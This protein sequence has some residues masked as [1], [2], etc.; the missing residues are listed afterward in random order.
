M[1][2]NKSEFYDSKRH[3]F[4][5]SNNI[6]YENC[7]EFYNSKDNSVLKKYLE[8]KKVEGSITQ[9]EIE[10]WEGAIDVDTVQDICRTAI[11]EY[12][13][14]DRENDPLKVKLARAALN[15][16]TVVEQDKVAQEKNN[17]DLF[18]NIYMVGYALKEIIVQKWKDKEQSIEDIVD[19]I[20]YEQ[21]EI[22]ENALYEKMKNAI[23]KIKTVSEKESGKDIQNQTMNYY[24]SVFISKNSQILREYDELQ[25]E[26]YVKEFEVKQYEKS[27]EL[28]NTVKPLK[29]KSVDTEHGENFTNQYDESEQT[30]SDIEIAEYLEQ[31]KESINKGKEVIDKY[32][33][34]K[35]H[36]TTKIGIE[37]AKRIK[38]SDKEL[39]AQKEN[40]IEIKNKTEEKNKEC[41][42]LEQ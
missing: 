8:I 15:S 19:N 27:Q 16:Q 25:M 39:D 38:V 12:H 6:D 41:E 40:L 26:Q 18:K 20:D 37:A 9:D 24:K 2:N 1:A 42:E 13:K 36:S 7:M 23:E 5:I 35:E 31:M 34:N 30:Q 28:I 21:V 29:A 10:F 32:N 4:S 14:E 22:K 3:K 33:T 17:R 11:V